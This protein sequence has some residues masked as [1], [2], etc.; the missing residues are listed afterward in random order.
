MVL[1]TVRLLRWFSDKND[2]RQEEDVWSM[3]ID[4]E[5]CIH[6]YYDVRSPAAACLLAP[7]GCHTV[8]DPGWCTV[9]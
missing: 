8:V 4:V 6:T 2:K 5:H 9:V 1:K 7:G 3:L